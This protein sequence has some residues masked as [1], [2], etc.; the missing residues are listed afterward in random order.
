MN[1]SGR[2]E[3]PRI[4]CPPDT[5][6]V[7]AHIILQS[8]DFETRSR[9]K[10]GTVTRPV[11]RTMKNL[12]LILIVI[13]LIQTPVVFLYIIDN[14]PSLF[15]NTWPSRFMFSSSEEHSYEANSLNVGAHASSYALPKPVHGQMK[16]TVTDSADKFKPLSS[17]IINEIKT[18]VLF[19]GISRSGHSIV[20]AILDSHPHIVV[21]NELDVFSRI[22]N[23]SSKASLF[24]LIWEKS[25]RKANL[26]GLKRSKK[27]YS[28]SVGGS[29]QGAYQS[30]INVIGDKHGGRIAK[31][32]VGN[33]ELFQSHL[34]KLRS[35]INMPI[36]VI[37]VIRNPYDNIATI[38]LYRHFDQSRINISATRKSNKTINIK[39]VI[40]EKAISYYFKL[41]QASELMRHQFNLD[42][43]DV[44]G[45]DLITNPMVIVNKMC[46][47]L[48]VSCS[49]NYLNTV[50]R[51]IFSSE[52][53]TRYKVAWTDE[54]L[55][56]IR[57]NILKYNTLKRY[58]D[59]D[60]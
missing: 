22:N 46:D 58:S 35:L 31:E 12:Y 51:K 11:R 33:P 15:Q 18:F 26:G 16:I 36:K 42:I 39:A 53:K 4:M 41:F 50:G 56:E 49:N 24:N 3:C 30:Y 47:F 20:A 17:S 10:Y 60:S 43:M 21:S 54:Q 44:H 34:N 6:P 5:F 32:F 55:S 48:R 19:V 7:P 37:H 1:L 23:H 45:K 29:W 27:G 9:E 2:T 8:Y 13:L 28:L 25:Y 14:Y 57:E 59:F 38:A 40:L 52:S